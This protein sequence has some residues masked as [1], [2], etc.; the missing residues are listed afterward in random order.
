MRLCDGR[1]FL[2]PRSRSASDQRPQ[3]SQTIAALDLALL[4]SLEVT[5]RLQ[6]DGPVNNAGFS[7]DGKIVVTASNDKTARVWDAATDAQIGKSMEHKASVYSAAFSLDGEDI[8]TASKDKTA[9]VWSV[10]LGEPIRDPLRHEDLVVSAAFSPDRSRVVTA[11][12]NTARVWGVTAHDE[13]TRPRETL[14]AITCNMLGTNHDIAGVSA[15]YRID[16][17]DPICTG[18]EPRP[19]PRA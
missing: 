8:V 2:A 3:L 19:T 1:E 17:K 16:V 11:S 4:G 9:L 18:N 10:F 12:D 7:P 15:R 13:T 14:V 6:H 5:P